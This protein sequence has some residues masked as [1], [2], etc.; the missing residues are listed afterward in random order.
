[1]N[2]NQLKISIVTSVLNGASTIQRLIDSLGVQTCKD[3]EH[4]VMD[5]GSQDGT[6]TILQQNDHHISYWES[7]PDRGIYWH[8]GEPLVPYIRPPPEMLKVAKHLNQ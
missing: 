7:S 4:I 1:M 8:P 5:G 3:R 6:A 2:G